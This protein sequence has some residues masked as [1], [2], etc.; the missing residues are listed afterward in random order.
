MKRITPGRRAQNEEKKEKSTW[1][2]YPR[3]F[4]GFTEP[5]VRL[6]FR[7]Q[8]YSFLLEEIN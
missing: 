7:L 4:M 1:D 6:P 8:M 5:P 2:F 3:N